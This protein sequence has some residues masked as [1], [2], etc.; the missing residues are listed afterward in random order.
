MS[1]ILIVED[2]PEIAMLE[3]DYL[4]IE[5]FETQVTDNG[6]MAITQ[7][8]TGDYD[9]I[10]L[11]LML[12]GCS[13][14]DVCRVIRDKTDVPILMVTARTESVDKIRGLG[15]GADD[16]VAKPFDPAELVA[17][18]KTQLRRYTR[19]N[20]G[21]AAEP[22]E[23]AEHDF[24]GLQISRTTHKCVLFGEELALTPL[25]FAILWYLCE[26]RGQV[27]PSE[28]L[29]EAVWGEKYMDSNNT[30]MSHIA[31]LREKMHEP[32]RKPKF[33]KTVWGVGYTIE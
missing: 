29:F 13:G 25:E 24:R 10:L 4:E 26:H 21:E 16:Y 28:E 5:G 15:L 12:P 18:V 7:A 17:R 33:I 9:L 27:V 19:Y 20:T 22:R 30:V 1:K 8:V 3:R 6:Q 23:T 14:Y 11:D 31:R 2:D 32:S